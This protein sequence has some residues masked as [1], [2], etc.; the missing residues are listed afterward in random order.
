MVSDME[1]Q[2]KQGYV[3][4]FFHANKMAPI[5]MMKDELKGATF[6][7]QQCFVVENWLHQIVLLCSLYLL[8]F[9]QK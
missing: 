4:E 5:D 6:S 9:P 1:V 7:Y 3:T 8:R 2:M